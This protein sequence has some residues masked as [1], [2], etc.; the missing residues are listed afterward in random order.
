MKDYLTVISERYDKQKFDNLK[1]DF[2]SPV[3]TRLDSLFRKVLK[4]LDVDLQNIQILDVGCGKGRWTRLIS[5]VTQRPQNITGLDASD[6]AISICVNLSPHID[7]YSCD[8]IKDRIRGKYDL[9]LTM[10][11][12]MHFKTQEEVSLALQNIHQAL[13]PNGIF[14]FYDAY[15]KNHFE[16][17]D[18]Q[19]SQGFHPKEIEQLITQAGFSKLSE[20]HIFKTF[21]G[22][23]HSSYFYGRLPFSLIRFLEVVTPSP[24]GNFFQVFRRTGE[25][26]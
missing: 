24:S 9:I 2:G 16:T 17:N 6:S 19:E 4:S 5:E 14:I 13:T 3:Q 22:K 7:Y 26:E 23:Y 10:D 20:F 25:T 8:I 21:L 1:P 12:F 11:L 15:A 18:G